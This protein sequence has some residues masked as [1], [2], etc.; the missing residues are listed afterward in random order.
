VHGFIALN[1]LSSLYHILFCSLCCWKHSKTHVIHIFNPFIKCTRHI[2]KLVALKH[3]PH[4][5]SFHKPFTHMNFSIPLSMACPGNSHIIS[6][7]SATCLV[8]KLIV[9][10]VM[11]WVFGFLFYNIRPQLLL[12][13]AVASSLSPTAILQ[14]MLHNLCSLKVLQ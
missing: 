12:S 8:S 14:S 5:D 9:K 10:F 13:H 4:Y 6:F 1:S 7:S 2:T 3:H 11:L